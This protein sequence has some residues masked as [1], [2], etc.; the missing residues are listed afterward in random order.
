MRSHLYWSGQCCAF[1]IRLIKYLFEKATELESC[2]VCEIIE[3]EKFLSSRLAILEKH[4]VA[5]CQLEEW[6]SSGLGQM[7]PSRI[8]FFPEFRGHACALK[9]KRK[10]LRR[11]QHFVQWA[12]AGAAAT[13]IRA[14]N[15]FFSFETHEQL[16]QHLL[17]T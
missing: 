6:S 1:W 14:K 16:R 12:N 4:G 8:L 13:Q 15:P 3:I 2:Q 11:V 7:G 10:I 9:E 5:S 17:E